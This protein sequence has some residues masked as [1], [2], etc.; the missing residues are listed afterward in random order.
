M[1]IK[2]LKQFNDHYGFWEGMSEEEKN[3]RIKEVMKTAKY[4]DDLDEDTPDY[5]GYSRRS[6]YDDYQDEAVR[7]LNA[8]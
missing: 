8:N 5:E 4:F 2:T 7:T 1:Q 3:K 6:D